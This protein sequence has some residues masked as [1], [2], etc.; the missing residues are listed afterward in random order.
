MINLPKAE[1]S[2]FFYKVKLNMY[3]LT[4]IISK[5][6]DCCAVWNE[7]TSG[8]AG[9]DIASTFIKILKNVVKDNAHITDIVCWSYNCVPQKRNS[10][11]SQAMPGFLSTNSQILSIKM[12]YSIPGHSFVHEVDSMDKQ[13]G[14]IMP[15]PELHS[16]LSKVK[17]N[18]PYR[19]LQ[20]TRDDF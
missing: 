2:S 4:G 18:Q 17:R 20:I 19:V 11:I 9:N 12:K 8:R 14:D 16:P 15:I 10:H 5:G 3:N 1:V 7:L 6:Q 13:V